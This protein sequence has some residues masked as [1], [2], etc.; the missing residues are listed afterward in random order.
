[1]PALPS[2][3]VCSFAAP[4]SR[5]MQPDAPIYQQQRSDATPRL[6]R[7]LRD[8]NSPLLAGRD[9]WP[10]P[11]ICHRMQRPVQIERTAPDALDPREAPPMA[12]RPRLLCRTRV[13]THRQD[14]PRAASP[15]NYSWV[16]SRGGNRL[17][18][19]T[20]YDFPR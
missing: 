6:A 8:N 15:D 20:E 10:T 17:T 3:V 12:P 4:T 18:T 14:L 16:R 9:L 5:H 19:R 11:P 7:W 1:M 2:A 13:D